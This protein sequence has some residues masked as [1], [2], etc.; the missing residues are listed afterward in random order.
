M[1]SIVPIAFRGARLADPCAELEGFTQDLHVRAGS[2]KT[3]IRPGVAHVGAVE[4]GPDALAHVHL[5]GRAG[6]SAASAHLGTIHEVVNGI[7]E[8]LVHVAADI[9]MQRDHLANGH[10]GF[11]RFHAQ[12]G[13]MLDVPLEM[14]LLED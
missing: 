3:K 14:A 10:G 4:A 5:L 2:S 7:A 8:R 12:R 11:S 13:E 1:L 6:V 9:R